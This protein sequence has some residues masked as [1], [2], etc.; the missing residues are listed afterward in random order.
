VKEKKMN[1]DNTYAQLWKV[2]SLTDAAIPRNP[3]SY[4]IEGLFSLPSLNIV[5][6][7]PG[8][9]KSLILADAAICVAAGIPWLPPYLPL[10]SSGNNDNTTPF[11][12]QQMPVLWVDFD[13]GTRRTHERFD[14]LT[15]ARN[16]QTSIPLHYV[17]IPEPRLDASNKSHIISLSQLTLSLN[18]QFI[19]IDNLGLIVGDTDENSAKMAQV[20][21]NLRWLAEATNAVIIIIH[22]Q[23]KSA[24]G[25]FRIGESLRGHS[26]I[27]ASLDL[28]LVVERKDNSDT[29]TITPTKERGAPILP[30][31][32]QFTFTHHPNTTELA[33]SQ[34]FFT[35]LQSQAERDLDIIKEQILTALK[36]YGDND[37]SPSQIELR[38]T[39]KDNLAIIGISHGINKI[40][41]A[42]NHLVYINTIH[43]ENG[44]NKSKLYSLP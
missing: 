3:L 34:F 20:L 35:T 22:H 37:I 2:Y 5:Y 19:V 15:K 43:E 33:T 38:N 21:G 1:N 25:N 17:S 11:T 41:G 18:I 16:L 7:A 30:I 28:A 44:L 42:I 8:S 23:R 14:S 12:T 32:A 39:V 31:T 13:N 27:E 6:G 36:T 9:M 24:T 29:I 4:A 10:A 26:S 40:R